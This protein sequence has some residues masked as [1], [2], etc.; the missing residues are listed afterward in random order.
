MK[1][2]TEESQGALA[3]MV[4]KALDVPGPQ[5]GYGIAHAHFFKVNLE[6]LA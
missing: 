6:N 4:L 2:E 3:L 5:H 1:E